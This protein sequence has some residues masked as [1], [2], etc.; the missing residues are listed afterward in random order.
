M[1]TW[2]TTHIANQDSHGP[3]IGLWIKRFH[4]IQ[5]VLDRAINR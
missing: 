1:E 3:T 5:T 2:P 4:P